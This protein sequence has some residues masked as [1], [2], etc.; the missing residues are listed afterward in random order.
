MVDCVADEI[1]VDADPVLAL[2]AVATAVLLCFLESGDDELEPVVLSAPAVRV[3]LQGH[4]VCLRVEEA[5][6]AKR[7]DGLLAR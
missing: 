7:V 1:V 3:V 5:A 4:E 6:V 2:K